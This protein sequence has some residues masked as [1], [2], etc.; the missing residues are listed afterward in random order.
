MLPKRL[1]DGTEAIPRHLSKRREVNR[2]RDMRFKVVLHEFD[3]SWGS[4]VV[5][6]SEISCV[7]MRLPQ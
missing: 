7:I 5:G 6:L 3:L 2:F 1:M 4:S